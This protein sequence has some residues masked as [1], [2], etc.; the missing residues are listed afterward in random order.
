MHAKRPP[1]PCPR[2]PFS[3]HPHSPT[4]VLPPPHPSSSHPSSY[5]FPPTRPPPPTLP[6]HTPEGHFRESCTPPS[7]SS[8]APRRPALRRPPRAARARPVR[9]GQPSWCPPR[10]QPPRRPPWRPAPR[11][12]PAAAL[13]GEKER[14]RREEAVKE[15]VICV[16][17]CVCVERE[18]TR[19]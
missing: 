13:E 3:N 5:S 16:F 2:P 11:P 7:S 9:Q 15:G 6:A 1:V 4:R 17:V 12:R 19:A 8:S 10:T 14:W 18:I